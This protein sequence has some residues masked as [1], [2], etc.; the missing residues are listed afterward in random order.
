MQKGPGHPRWGLF[1]ARFDGVARLGGGLGK[2]PSRGAGREMFWTKALGRK[3][4][5]AENRTNRAVGV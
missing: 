2:V 5:G 4:N 3:K 1:R